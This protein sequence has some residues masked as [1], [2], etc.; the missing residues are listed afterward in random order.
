MAAAFVSA[1]SGAAVLVPALALIRGFNWVTALLVCAVMPVLLWLVRHR[2]RRRLAFNRMVR[3][4]VLNV[5]TARP[6]GARMRQGATVAACAVL[7]AIVLGLAAVSTG[8]RLSVPAD[9]D[10]LWRT[11]Q[12]LSGGTSWDPIAA[13]AAV[14]ARI[15]V[16]DALV[17]VIA[18]RICLI[19]VTLL[20]ATAGTTRLLRHSSM[21]AVLAV[22]F[23]FTAPAV[24]LDVWAIA[25]LAMIAVGALVM[26][27]GWCAAVAGLLAAAHLTHASPHAVWTQV[28]ET[29]SLEHPAAARETLRLAH[30]STGDDWLLVAPP[31]QALEID[32]RE[33]SYDLA[34]FVSRFRNQPG[35]PEFRFSLPVRTLYV[36]VEKQPLNVSRPVTGV[37][38]LD[39]QPAAYRVQS[40]R[41]RL[42]RDARRLCDEYRRT[43]SGTAI[44]YDDVA[45]RIYKFEL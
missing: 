41:D 1:W 19:A 26:R 35:R 31:E 32:G 17:A 9:F 22:P 40:E 21:A 20:A 7:A 12:L 6:D 36:M 27:G 23:A 25:L 38:F 45:L 4:L 3:D 44:A 18:V 34:R 39:S 28:G 10:T 2:G 11:R 42:E 14:V 30:D 43:H 24:S 15:A 29:A 33:R 5:V 8:L 37:R 13:I 16:V